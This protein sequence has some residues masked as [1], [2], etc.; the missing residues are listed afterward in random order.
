MLLPDLAIWHDVI[1]SI[2]IELIDF[3]AKHKLVDVDGAL[4]L[5]RDCFKLLRFD[6]QIFAF[7]DL[8]A[9]DDVSGL[10]LAANG[11]CVRSAVLG[12]VGPL[13]CMALASSLGCF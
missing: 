9:L 12:N 2:E 4:T 5:D 6:L 3:L 10:D 1:G 13:L 7:A 8:V 11:D